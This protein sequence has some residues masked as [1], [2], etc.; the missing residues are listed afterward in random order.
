MRIA[1]PL[2]TTLA[3]SFL[4]LALLVIP[5]CGSSK[6]VQG[7]GAG[8]AGGAVIG[9]VIGTMTGSTARGA[10]IGAAIGGTAGAII[11][12]QMDKQAAEMQ[13]D[14][15]G[16]Q[17]ER[18]GEGIK[19]TFDSGILFA[20]DSSELQ[21]ASRM[22]IQQLSTILNKYPD[23]DIV[24]EGDTDST[25]SEEH[26]QELSERRAESVAVYAVEL[27]V[28][29]ERIRIIGLG[30]TNPV[31]PNDTEAGRQQNR[32]VELAI[33]ANEELKKAAKAGDL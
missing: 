25:G 1:F 17:V 9:G 8:A 30:E 18:V 24:I 31:A 4:C 23:T 14:L 16:A 27:G 6:A 26:N 32:R 11:G 20:V 15:E 7:G 19:I 22:N 5:G 3:I 10:I 33:F 28:A 21:E 13:R 29:A 12:S 2:R